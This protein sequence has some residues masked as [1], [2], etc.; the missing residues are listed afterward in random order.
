MTTVT[1]PLRPHLRAFTLIELLTVIAIIG[2]LAAITI[3][4][5]SGVRNSAKKT[6]TRIQFTQWSAGI[7]TF[8]QV[9]GFYPRFEVTG[10][11][12]KVNGSLAY[13]GATLADEDYRFRELLSGKGA[14]SIIG[15]FEFASAEKDSS[16][17]RQN[18]KRQTF[19]TFDISEVVSTT[20]ADSG[21]PDLKADG[22]LKDAFG[23]VDIVV[24][25]D[26][27]NDGFINDNDLATGVSL[28][29]PVI[30]RGGYGTLTSAMVKARIDASDPKKNGVRSDVIFYSPGK[31]SGNSP[32]AEI[33]TTE[34]VWSW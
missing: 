18:S 34:A 19:V 17:A 14:K 6:K 23:N 25:V 26:R 8:K 2:I 30:A 21:D 20:G 24:L 29:P 12:H 10:G 27:N 5:V 13:N 15:G 11:K 32:A 3:P 16:S 31:G 4:T 7:R 1:Q 33:S 9:Y 28:F 22:A